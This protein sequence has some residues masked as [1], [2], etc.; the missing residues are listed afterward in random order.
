MTHSEEEAAAFGLLNTI[1]NTLQSAPEE[2]LACL[3]Q[4]KHSLIGHEQA[5][6]LYVDNNIIQV[7]VRILE[8]EHAPKE[9][10][11]EA[12]TCIG[13]LS[14]GIIHSVGFIGSNAYDCIGGESFASKLLQAGVLGPLISTLNLTTSPPKLVLSSL[15]TLNTLF[16]TCPSETSTP[17]NS[18]AGIITSEL[19]SNRQA[20]KH[21]QIILSQTSASPSTQQQIALAATLISKSCRHGGSGEKAAANM[22]KHQIMLVNDGILEALGRRL[23]GFIVRD[24]N[25]EG[26]RPPTRSPKGL[27]DEDK[28]NSVPIPAP[29]TAQLAPLMDAIS[30]II[31]NNPVVTRNDSYRQHE[32]L[33]APWILSAFPASSQAPQSRPKAK[34]KS[35]TS[36]PISPT[37]LT[38]S[39][40]PPLSASYFP[41]GVPRGAYAQ[42]CASDT[43]DSALNTP[44]PGSDTEDSS[45]RR[46]KR[47]RKVDTMPLE[48]SPLVRWLI[49]V[50]RQGDALTRLMAA[51]LLINL[52]HRRTGPIV[53]S[54][55]CM[56]L[57]VLVRL[58]DDDAQSLAQAEHHKGGAAVGGQQLPQRVEWIIRERAPAVLADLINDSEQ[59][60]KAAVEAHAIKKLAGMLKRTFEVT[61]SDS[62]TKET[63]SVLGMK[64]LSMRLP[65]GDA[66]ENARLAAEI[67]SPYKVHR[68]KVRESTL[69]CISGLASLKDEYR[70]LVIDS[71]VLPYIVASLRPISE[72]KIQ[73]SGPS[74][75]P[76]TAAE[77]NPPRVL[78][79]A[80]YAVKSLSRSVSLLRT[81][82]IDNGVAA[83]VTA[84]LKSDDV[85]VKNAATMALC[86]LLLEFSP[87]QH[88][89]IESGAL[90][91]LCEQAHSTNAELKLNS[92]WALKHYIYN[93]TPDVK[94]STLAELGSEW[95]VDLISWDDDLASSEVD[96]E[97]EDEDERMA[98]E[99]DE[100]VAYG[101]LFSGNTPQHHAEESGEESD[102]NQMKDSIGQL[103]RRRDSRTPMTSSASFV[104]QEISTRAI[105]RA[106]RQLLEV[107]EQGLQF[108]RNLICGA[109]S[110]EMLDTL[111]SKVGQDR[112][113]EILTRKTRPRPSLSHRIRSGRNPPTEI[114]IPIIYILIHIAANHP[115]HRETLIQQTELLKNLL[116]LFE[117][118][119]EE[120]RVS[121]AWVVINLTWKDDGA[122]EAS[123][124]LRAA[125]LKRLGFMQK[126][127]GLM[128]DK[129]L[130]VKERAK[131]G[132][133]Q[134]RQCLGDT[135]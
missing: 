129:E 4:I 107:Q 51:S 122:D 38:A 115:R 12:G 36:H 53:K 2:A 57:P 98:D 33:Y 67:S 90:K 61:P 134:M 113:Y 7:L 75:A 40:F 104:E 81:S 133:Y 63:N 9:L 3:K 35:I 102:V 69:R 10:K 48:D 39:A 109:N 84:L 64:S 27:D 103:S 41:A 46:G 8:L 49:N 132:L 88:L 114:L 97:Y 116:P 80:A 62:T 118:E 87:M 77:G 42:S 13:S 120:V 82:L 22:E 86:N 21:I 110:P 60:Q 16:D 24:R 71:G 56:V 130:D 124:K 94:T 73:D 105:R 20:L 59:M 15:R 31:K 37:M 50:V 108:L 52:C 45:R 72:I 85:E 125:E 76:A 74:S 89:V 95:L 23:A 26:S 106:R 93:A 111:F 123:C 14:Y 11:L 30:V 18:I 117:H 135:A 127:E 68:M 79:A 92:I 91:I 43:M 99:G 70:K 54:I 126:L 78:I 47:S 58:L 83:P 65:D 17:S 5:K 34:H 32:F 28:E 44:A 119:H 6:Q 1:R 66:E 100:N 112:V 131:T 25:G 128:H 121:L 55:E 96:E 101:P 19:Y 29:V